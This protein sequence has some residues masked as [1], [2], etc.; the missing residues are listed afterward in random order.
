MGGTSRSLRQEQT[1]SCCPFMTSNWT[2]SSCWQLAAPFH[3]PIKEANCTKQLILLTSSPH[4]MMLRARGRSSLPNAPRAWSLPDAIRRSNVP[5]KGGGHAEAPQSR[6]TC[7]HQRPLRG[8]K[9]E[10]DGARWERAVLIPRKTPSPG[11]GTILRGAQIRY[12]HTL[13]QA[14]TTGR[15]K[16]VT[17]S[18][19]H[20][21]SLLTIVTDFR[22]RQAIRN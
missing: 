22:D 16:N 4:V 13:L 17:K 1:N 15:K 7:A 2:L 3:P 12:I 6:T 20:P 11:T 19:S 5:T 14:F 10:N 8:I 9:R 18:R 21:C